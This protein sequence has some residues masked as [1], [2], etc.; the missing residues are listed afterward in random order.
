MTT[1]DEFFARTRENIQSIDKV[2]NP[3]CISIEGIANLDD[4]RLFINK[5]LSW[6]K[7][8]ERILEEAQDPS[9]P[10][11]ERIKFLAI[12]GSNLDEFFMVRVSALRQQ[13]QRGA[14]KVPPDGMTPQEQLNA[15]RRE[16]TSLLN[17][18]EEAW[19]RELLPELS[20]EGIHVIRVSDLNE[21]Q[22]FALRK[23]FEH[24]IFPTLTPLA[25]DVSHPFPFI[26]NLS[27][28]LAVVLRDKQKRENIARVKVPT[29][30]F[31]R[32]QQLFLEEYNQDINS[33]VA[34]RGVT[35][36]YLED[37]IASNLDRLF[38][39]MEIVA[40]YPFR[41]TRDAEMEIRVDQASDLLTVIEE[42]IDTRRSGKPIRLEVDKSMPE[43][44]RDVFMKNLGLNHD[45][46]YP[47]DGP[48]GLVDFWQLLKTDRPDLKD[49]P[50]I[51]F[52]PVEF[53][54]DHDP[55]AAISNRDYVL[56]HP[57]DSFNVTINLLKKAATNPNVL[58]IKITLYRIDKKSPIIDAL[59][60]ARLNRKNVTVLVELKAKF[61]EENNINWAKQLEQAG[62]HV[63]YGFTDIKVHAKLCLIVRREG[64]KIIRYSHLSSGNYNAVT[65]RIYG[66]I[67]YITS[68]PEIGSE[69]NDIFNFLTGYS[70]KD[71]YKRLL[72]APKVLKKEVI[73]R[74]DR[75]IEQQ[76]LKGDGYIAI[77]L[78]NLEEKDIIKALYR[79]SQAGVRVDLN[80]RAL[81]CLRPGVKGISENIR[82]ISIIGRFLEH[83]RILLLQKRRRRGSPTRK[84]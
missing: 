77:K 82:E 28:N 36:L 27:L 29:D 80:V 64:E 11:L 54:E 83:T 31:P 84:Q 14:L 3:D 9:H 48:L 52:T 46:V 19:N 49:Q 50:F 62:V 42:S 66:D 13:V 78:N 53:R 32:F 24:Q 1:N 10:L 76:K 5:E 12:C 72:V 20:A 16:V 35:L 71:D 68:N 15:I 2:L 37:I 56:Y 34:D 6:L 57:Y 73:R 70:Q 45:L 74:I 21:N 18:H 25:M 8:N 38:P 47:F 23:Y 60:E 63:V 30:I 44:L 39:G 67:S 65:S 7:L 75:E 41:L 26:S 43:S 69:V 55:F 40:A 22:R 59:L 58:A 81:C 4:P 17:K 61:D 33:C 79:A 51:P